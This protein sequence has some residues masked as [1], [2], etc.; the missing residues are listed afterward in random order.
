[1]VFYPAERTIF[2][3]VAILAALTAGL[4]WSKGIAFDPSEYIAPAIVVLSM[5]LLGWF[6]RRV[7]RFEEAALAAMIFGLFA[8]DALTFSTLNMVILPRPGGTIDAA[9][10]GIDSWVGYSWLG[11]TTWISNFPAFSDIL[12]FLYAQTVNLLLGTYILLAV[13]NNRRRLHIL[14]YTC[15]LASIVAISFWSLLPS[16]GASAYWTLP[17]DINAI[18]RPFASSANGV[19][20]NRIVAEGISDISGL[21]VGG[22]IALPSY[23]TVMALAV[24]FGLWTYWPLRL[25][26]ILIFAFSVPAILVHGGH[27]FID[28]VAGSLLTCA[29][30]VLSTRFY[31][32]QNG[33]AGDENASCFPFGRTG[34]AHSGL[35]N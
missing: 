18:V 5:L 17:E 4:I 20:L 16:V 15:I 19:E 22:L 12:R 21:N 28:I 32:Y 31:D 14:A 27:H 7:Y 30:W 2:S 6:F 29:C 13:L 33:I 26:A 23:H 25:P 3:I 1:M 8:F 34:R 10:V 35:I 9:L 24:V 11:F